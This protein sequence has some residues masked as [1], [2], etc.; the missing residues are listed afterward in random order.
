MVDIDEIL[1]AAIRT[2]WLQVNGPASQS[3]HQI[4]VETA[5]FARLSNARALSLLHPARRAATA[6]VTRCR[7]PREFGGRRSERGASRGGGPILIPGRFDGAP[8]TIPCCLSS[9][10]LLP[11]VK[12]IA[13]YISRIERA[14]ESRRRSGALDHDQIIVLALEAGC[15]KVRGARAQPAR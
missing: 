9:R 7:T 12:S 3:P 4:E 15:G 8:P 1:A 6:N 14:L 2:A 11:R 13:A 10:R 5:E